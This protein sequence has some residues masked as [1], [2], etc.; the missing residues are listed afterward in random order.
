MHRILTHSPRLYFWIV[1]LSPPVGHIVFN[2][3]IIL[4]FYQERLRLRSGSKWSTCCVTFLMTNMYYLMCKFDF[5]R[6]MS[7][8]IAA[9]E[10]NV[11]REFRVRM[12]CSVRLS[13]TGVMMMHESGSEDSLF[14]THPQPH[15]EVYRFRGSIIVVHRVRLFCFFWIHIRLLIDSLS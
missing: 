9:K 2:A 14:R 7:L 12:S 8:V 13:R 3:L 10:A 5:K 4:K 6:D 11:W 15:R 1:V